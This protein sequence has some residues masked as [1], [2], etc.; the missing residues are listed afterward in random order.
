MIVQETVR[1]APAL[2]VWPHTTRTLEAAIVTWRPSSIAGA[3]PAN[4]VCPFATIV[5]AGVRAAAFVSVMA[6]DPIY[7]TLPDVAKL[8]M[9]R[10]GSCG[11]SR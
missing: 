6:S 1:V 9:V 4:R 11:A 3:P 10:N 8:T 5:G 2:N 7:R